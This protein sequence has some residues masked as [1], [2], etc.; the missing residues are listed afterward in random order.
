MITKLPTLKKEVTFETI[1]GVEVAKVI[2]HEGEMTVEI[3]TSFQAH[4]KWEEHFESTVGYDLNTYTT[5]VKKWSKNP[6]KDKKVNFVGAMKLLYCYVNSEQLP[7]FKAFAKLFDY[8]I[9][10]QILGKIILIIEQLGNTV[11]KN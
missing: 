8:E 7:T 4:L 3:D 10:E 2:R 1:D 9:A 6:N 11:S 5:M